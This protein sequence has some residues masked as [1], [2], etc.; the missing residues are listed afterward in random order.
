MKFLK[1]KIVMDMIDDI[2]LRN[3]RESR[4]VGIER[5]GK[6]GVVEILRNS[7]LGLTDVK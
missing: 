1:I 7:M 6:V 5:G 3:G 4:L 2:Y